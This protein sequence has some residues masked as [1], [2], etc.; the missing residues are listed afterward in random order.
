M[1]SSTGSTAVPINEAPTSQHGM[2][3]TFRPD[4]KVCHISQEP[5]QQ[6]AMQI[7]GGG[8]VKDCCEACLCELGIDLHPAA[9]LSNVR[10]EY[11]SSPTCI[12]RG[13]S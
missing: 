5:S 6:A 1:E 4:T 3:G 10:L 9:A 12:F 13:S 7:R 2:A 11:P 8:C